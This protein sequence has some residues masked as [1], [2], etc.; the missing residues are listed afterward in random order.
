[1]KKFLLKNADIL[2]SIVVAI[3]LYLWIFTPQS[4]LPSNINVVMKGGDLAQNY[5]G[6]ALYRSEPFSWDLFAMSSLQYPEVSSALQTDSSPL[7]SFVFKLLRPLGFKAEYQYFGIWTL[8]NFVMTAIFSVLLFRYIFNVKNK[9]FQ[10]R[11]HLKNTILIVVCSVFFIV[12]PIMLNRAFHHIN[13]TAHWL[14]LASLLMYVQ[15]TLRVRTWLYAGLL[16]FISFGVHPYFVAMVVPLFMALAVKKLLHKEISLKHL[17]LGIVFL[18][19]IVGFCLF[20]FHLSG[21][22]DSRTGFGWHMANL[23]TFINPHNNES[24]FIPRMANIHGGEWEGAAYFGLGLLLLIAATCWYAV[25]YGYSYVVR[26][27]EMAIVLLCFF[28]FAISSSVHLGN[29]KLVEYHLPDFIVS[30]CNKLRS[31]GRF[32]WVLWYVLAY[33]AVFCAVK[34]YKKRVVYIIPMLLLIQIVDLQPLFNTKRE[35]IRTYSNTEYVNQLQSPQWK[36]LFAEYQHIVLPV[37]KAKNA[38]LYNDIWFRVVQYGATVNT[39]YLTLK[40]TNNIEQTQ[41]AQQNIEKGE[42]PQLGY[43]A[44]YIMPNDMYE[45][46]AKN[47]AKRSFVQ[48]IHCVD[49][50]RY[51][52]I[53]N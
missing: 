5:L 44:L 17:L 22:S 6:G 11:E 23:N 18:I 14:I 51:C 35:F 8:F 40:K 43:R 32:I 13:L 19:L 41:K 38:Q 4:L 3:L 27:K 16:V 53:R 50:V 29:I 2:I 34:M 36:D 9:L 46:V 49:G 12:S 7:V 33:V 21:N 1:M 24:L 47:S 10:K 30:I 42:L 48:H 31:S 26:H 15:N 37:F 39:G 45:R 28:L 20:C 25:Q 52:V